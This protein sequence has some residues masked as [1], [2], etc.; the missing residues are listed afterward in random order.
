MA[1]FVLSA[2]AQTTTQTSQGQA[3]RNLTMKQTIALAQEQSIQ[4]MMSKNVYASEYWRYRSYRAGRLPSLIMNAGIGNINRS[5]QPLQN[6]ETG[7]YAYR[8]VFTFENDVS[9]FLRQR[10]AATG[11]EIRLQSSLRRLDQFSPDNLT[12]YSQPITLQYIQPLF[13]YNAMRW[14]KKIAPQE[15]EAA[16]VEYLEAMEEVTI[17]A[18]SSFWSLAMAELNRDNAVNNHENSTRLYR[19][20][21]ERLK[22]GTMSRNE[23]L[24][25]ELSAL[26]DSLSMNSYQISYAEMRNYLASFVGL[27]DD[28]DI[29]LSIDYTLPG[30]TLDYQQV[31]ARALENSSFELNQRIALLEADQSVAQARESRGVEVSFNAQFGLSQSDK[32]LANAYSGLRD[33]QVAGFQVS[34]PILDWGQG[35]GRVKLAQ[36]Q[37]AT[38]RYRQEQARAD[39]EREIF[40]GV[41]EFNA[42]QAQCD[43]ALRA[44][45]IADEGFALSVASFERGTITVLELNTAQSK[46]D[47]ADRN[48]I[49]SLATYWNSYFTLR[50][51]TLYDFLSKTDIADAFGDEE[52]N[53]LVEN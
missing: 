20:A 11:G 24:Q 13:T 35:R 33:Q 47:S 25:L 53:R 38:T 32:T 52:F 14:E 34:I 18:A 51:T 30:I 28:A 26:Q 2:T 5:M 46:K 16:R 49:Q 9:L 12:W 21:Q 40:V 31:L 3:T 44:K 39:Y 50:K 15:Y 10:I 23:V 22:L 17:R 43:G 41:M 7:E 42:Q 1:A 27:R 8:P 4:S 29:K 19:I 37:A 48:Y 45:R 6:Y 36:S